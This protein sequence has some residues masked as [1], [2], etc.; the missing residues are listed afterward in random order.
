MRLD[1]RVKKLEFIRASIVAAE[2][3]P[4]PDDWEQRVKRVMRCPGIDEK[5]RKCKEELQAREAGSQ[6]RT[7]VDAPARSLEVAWG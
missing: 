2:N 3:P 4:L 7:C 6:H 1:T 5:Y